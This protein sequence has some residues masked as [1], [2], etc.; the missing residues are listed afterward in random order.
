MFQHIT[1]QVGIKSVLNAIHSWSVYSTA[2]FKST[3]QYSLDYHHYIQ[4]E[5]K[6]KTFGLS[7]MNQW[8]PLRWLRRPRLLWTSGT[9]S[10]TWV[11]SA[12][13]EGT[14]S[15]PKLHEPMGTP[16]GISQPESAR[17]LNEP[18]GSPEAQKE[19]PTASTDRL[20]LSCC[21][22]NDLALGWS[23]EWRDGPVWPC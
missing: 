6:R 18:L 14:S 13:K 7:R 9:S 22:C 4:S 2:R 10:G 3:K 5:Y 23:T 12:S 17:P 1:Q 11:P 15:S 8:P 21:L 20:P 16:S 19:R